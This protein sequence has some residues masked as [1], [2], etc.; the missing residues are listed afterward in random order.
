MANN[1]KKR[2]T[3]LNCI[4]AVSSK[5]TNYISA[6]V[7]G[8][9][10]KPEVRTAGDKFLVTGSMPINNRSKS[11]NAAVGTAFPEDQE[12]IWVEVNFWEQRAERFQKLLAKSNASS[13]HMVMVGSLSKRTYTGKDGNE[14]AKVVL[15]VNDW[16]LMPKT[17]GNATAA[18]STPA[19]AP[20]ADPFADGFGAFEDL[21]SADNPFA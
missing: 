4:H 3:F 13:I 20:A 12:T 18:T 10:C 17:S 19:A 1:N 11:I 2:Y 16:F 7:E 6:T 9:L 5:G 21:S 15:T 14:K 8:Y